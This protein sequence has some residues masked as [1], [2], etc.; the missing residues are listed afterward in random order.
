VL[1]WVP[2]P[3]QNRPEKYST[4]FSFSPSFR[5]GN[6]GT[7]NPTPIA[8]TSPFLTQRSILLATCSH[9]LCER[10]INRY[11]L[12]HRSPTFR[13]ARI[14]APLFLFRV[15]R[16][17]PLQLRFRARNPLFHAQRLRLLYIL[18]FLYCFLE[19]SRTAQSPQHKH[20]TLQAS[21]HSNP[22]MS[23]NPQ[24]VADIHSRH[25]A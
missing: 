22:T 8:I 20:Q 16:S 14:L 19:A 25:A 5:R 23:S 11:Q 15:P 2:P 4:S 1:T 9:R 12:R 3:P 10:G 13:I 17:H 18:T 6:L 24:N 21:I 7:Q